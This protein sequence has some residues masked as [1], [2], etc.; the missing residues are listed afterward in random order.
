M[1]DAEETL[2][3][4]KEWLLARLDVG[5]HPLDGLD[6]EAARRTIEALTG[7]DP[8]PWTAA[9]GRGCSTTACAC[10]R[11]NGGPA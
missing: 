7:L 6:P 5:A 2:A 3:A 8:E 1:G 11:G 4:G 9:W 10:R